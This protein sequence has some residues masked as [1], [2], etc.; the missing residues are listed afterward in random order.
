LKISL[1][2]LRCQ[3]AHKLNLQFNELLAE[4]PM[5]TPAVGDLVLS[6]S[7]A[8]VRLQGTIETV[9]K[10]QCHTC[11]NYFSRFLS[12]ELN[13]EF[14]YEDYL[15]AN[16][17]K[18][19]DR[20]LQKEDFFETVPYHGEID[21]SDIVF[22]AITIAIPVY[23]SCGDQCPGFPVYNKEAGETIKKL[24]STLDDEPNEPEWVDPR[25]HNL[26]TILPKDNKN[27]K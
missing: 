24:P 22:Q 7:T 1:S 13:E 3:P 27:E 26:K 5:A 16:A 19:K 18:V 11:L 14:V 20:E 17:L 15:N 2:E 9:V 12:L 4:V 6:A 23:C 25:W 10:L 8:L 21:V